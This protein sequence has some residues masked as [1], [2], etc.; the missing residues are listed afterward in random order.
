MNKIFHYYLKYGYIILVIFGWLELLPLEKD[1]EILKKIEL[2]RSEMIALV[3]KL[4]LSSSQAIKCSQELDNLLNKYQ[5]IDYNL[6][7]IKTYL[8]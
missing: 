8:N 7:K 2:K 4:G 3:N 1:N 5:N 6:T